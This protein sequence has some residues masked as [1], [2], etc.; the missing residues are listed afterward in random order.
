MWQWNESEYCNELPVHYHLLGALNVVY[1]L[2]IQEIVVK[3]TRL[4]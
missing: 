3:D 2:Y 4:G 1:G